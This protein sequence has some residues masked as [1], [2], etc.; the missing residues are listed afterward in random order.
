SPSSLWI[1]VCHFHRAQCVVESS[2][3]LGWVTC[4]REMQRKEATGAQKRKASGPLATS[5]D[6][7][8]RRKVAEEIGGDTDSITAEDFFGGGP[9]RRVNAST[10]KAVVKEEGQLVFHFFLSFLFFSFF[11]VA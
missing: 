7:K 4:S 3:T 9:K 8:K 2:Q 11:L 1:R 10:T 5:R 6:E